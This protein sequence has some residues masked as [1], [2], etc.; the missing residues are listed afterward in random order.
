MSPEP[1]GGGSAPPNLFRCKSASVPGLRIAARKS[2]SARSC[3]GDTATLAGL[4]ND[5]AEADADADADDDDDDDD[6]DGDN[7]A[8]G[9]P[10]IDGDDND[11]GL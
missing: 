11:L 9:A 4:L 10:P 8:A 1:G 6:D 3:S 5:D 2:E 7:A